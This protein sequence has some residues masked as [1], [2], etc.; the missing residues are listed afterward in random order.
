MKIKLDGDIK[1]TN[2]NFPNYGSM[3]L[4]DTQKVYEFKGLSKQQHNINGN[5]EIS[6]NGS[7]GAKSRLIIDF[8]YE[9]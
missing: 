4:N 2:F 7:V 8:I 9:G 6:S 1:I 3:N 5:I